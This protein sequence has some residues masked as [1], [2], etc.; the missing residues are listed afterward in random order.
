MDETTALDDAGASVAPD[1][2]TGYILGW[3]G[4]L[5]DWVAMLI[6]SIWLSLVIIMSGFILARTGRTPVWALLLLFPP[7]QVVAIWVFAFI[8]WP[9]YDAAAHKQR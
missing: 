5:P 3:M 4:Q 9:R 2:F 7:I 1:L 8:R 6:V